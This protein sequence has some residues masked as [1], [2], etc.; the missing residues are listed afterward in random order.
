[1]TRKLNRNYSLIVVVASVAILA[2][3]FAAAASTMA[4][5]PVPFL[6]QPL[7]PD[8]TAPGG[9]GFT[10]TVNGGWFVPASVVN[11]NGSPRATTFV[12]GTQLTAAIL[13]SD[14]ATA[15]TAEVTV[16]NPSTGGGASNTLFF[17]IAVPEA[18]VD[19][20]PAAF[21]DSGGGGPLAI[22]DLNADGYPDIVAGTSVLL[23]NGHGWFSPPV[24]PGGASSV[25]VAD[26]NGDGKLDLIACGGSTMSV[27][28]GNGDGTFQPAVSYYAG[29]SPCYSVAVADLNGDGKPDV[30]VAVYR[31]IAVLLGNGDG[32]FQPAVTYSWGGGDGT[33]WGS[34]SLAIADL[35]GDGKP[36][37]AVAS[38]SSDYPWYNGSVGVLLG[39]GDGTFQ[40]A[41][42]YYSGG[43]Y[44]TSLAVGDLNGDGK[45]DIVVTDRCLTYLCGTVAVLLGNGDGSFQP[46][47]GYSSGGDYPWAVVV[48]DMNED[49]KPD[50]VVANLYGNLGVLL[51]N[52]DGTFQPAV[53]HH[54]PHAGSAA[55]ADVNGDGKPDIVFS[56]TEGL[57]GV[58]LTKT[59]VATK[60][61]VT[62]SGSPTLVGQPVTF[63][64]TATLAKGT[65]PDGELVEFYDGVA[66]LGSGKL[67]A[68]VAEYSTSSLTAKTHSIKA[69]Y[70]GDNTFELSSGSVRQVVDRYPTTTALS[71][72][73]NPSNY[74]QAVT[75]TATVTSSGPNT[76][77]RKVE[78]KNGTKSMGWVMLSNGVAT[79]TTSKL[80]VGSYSI[81]AE[82][83]GN[84]NSDESTS[85]VLDQ[86]VE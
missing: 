35:N 39:N 69:T 6:D 47:V 80:A 43:W 18:S 59:G 46:A 48:A 40:P 2:L 11:W 71:S 74:G 84:A 51:G 81:T 86:V 5:N 10:L 72:S 57:V 50:L 83:Q 45:P 30:A 9:A 23:G 76:P 8:A 63:T 78:F 7:V 4:Q 31:N 49:G 25:A 58:L 37:L 22:A 55:V 65:I 27:L 29:G 28:L 66:M 20:L 32:T 75:F 13:A 53:I 19:F 73:L 34:N 54:S 41:V 3:L 1:M 21:Y 33:S 14:I 17:S 68:G 64:A 56:T 82:Y 77:T 16:V 85:P 12:S 67:T 62:T 42:D 26:V 44:A 60:T 70:P 38:G 52:G 36:D 61:T 24:S 79:L 15:S